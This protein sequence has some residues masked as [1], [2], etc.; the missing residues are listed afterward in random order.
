MTAKRRTGTEGS[1]TR[2]QL[3]DAT[4]RLML[5]EGYAAVSSRR[6]ASALGVTSALVHYYFPGLD[7]LF[8][9]VFRRRADEELARQSRV[10]A[11]KDSLAELFALGGERSSMPLMQEFMALANHRKVIQGEIARYAEQ[12]RTLQVDAV[13]SRLGD[14]TLPGDMPP[15]ALVVLATAV[16]R[17]LVMEH[18]VGI[19][20]GHAETLEVVQRYLQALESQPVT[21]RGRSVLRS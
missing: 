14:R 6:V 19:D 12:F 4:E 2:L 13:V 8:V 16:E 15:V 1:K 7:D 11:S 9:A 20:T 10:L 3:L 21:R 5:D 17:I 18:A